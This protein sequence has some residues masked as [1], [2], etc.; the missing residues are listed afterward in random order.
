MSKTRTTQSPVIEVIG[1]DANNLR[2]IDVTLPA[3]HVHGCARAAGGGNWLHPSLY[4]RAPAGGTLE[5]RLPDGPLAPAQAVS[6]GARLADAL[7]ALHEK[8]CLHGDVKPS[9]RPSLR[10]IGVRLQDV[11]G[12]GSR[13]RQPHRAEQ[14]HAVDLEEQLRTC[15]GVSVGASSSM[16]DRTPTGQDGTT[17]TEFYVAGV[18]Q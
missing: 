2:H 5:D 10:V 17:Y 18:P 1:A 14:L 7:A 8:K 11:A 12:R 15:S 9:I 13:D 16:S 6:V 3:G 4:M